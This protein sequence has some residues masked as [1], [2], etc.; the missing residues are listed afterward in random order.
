MGA[1]EYGLIGMAVSWLPIG[2]LAAYFYWRDK[3][4]SSTENVR[5]AFCT[6]MGWISGIFIFS[7]LFFLYLGV[8]MMSITEALLDDK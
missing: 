6:L 7:G 1:L 4:R 2:Y 5:F 3:I 8:W